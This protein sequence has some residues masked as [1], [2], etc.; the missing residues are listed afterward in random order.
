[1]CGDNDE[2]TK[3]K[4]Q[5]QGQKLI[6]RIQAVIFLLLA[7]YTIVALFQALA[8]ITRTDLMLSDQPPRDKCVPM[9]DSIK[10]FK[11]ANPSTVA[12]YDYR[13]GEAISRVCTNE[14]VAK[15]RAAIGTKYAYDPWIKDTGCNV[16]GVDKQRFIDNCVLV[17]MQAGDPTTCEQVLNITPMPY[18]AHWNMFVELISGNKTNATYSGPAPK[19]SIRVTRIS[20]IGACSLDTMEPFYDLNEN[21]A[22]VIKIGVAVPFILMVFQI[23]ALYSYSKGGWKAED[24]WKLAFA[25]R[26]VPGSMYMLYFVCKE[27]QDGRGEFPD[28]FLTFPSWLACFVQ[29]VLEGIAVPLVS[30]LGCSLGRYPV[31]LLLLILKAVKSLFDVTM[32]AKNRHEESEPGNEEDQRRAWA[33][34]EAAEAAE[35][36][37][38][39]QQQMQQQQFPSPQSFQTNQQNGV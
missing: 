15:T 31:S 30:I 32:Y 22:I 5:T 12:L 1:M 19:C 33:Q 13:A 23:V 14:T 7:I 34:A 11:S 3:H 24:G 18:G 4:Q 16:L 29:D 26:G 25:L 20:G 10:A 27:G 2:L 21:V 9:F 6:I 38:K 35:K 28:T 17:N 37:G 39:Q 36:T 8:Q